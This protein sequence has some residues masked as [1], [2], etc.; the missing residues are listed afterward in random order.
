MS[1]EAYVERELAVGQFLYCKLHCDSLCIFR[2][3]DGLSVEQVL[4]DVRLN[5]NTA[6]LNNGRFVGDERKIS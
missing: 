3:K 5:D 6:R 2:D 4:L 1:A